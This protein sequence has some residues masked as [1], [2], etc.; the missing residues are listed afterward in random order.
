MAGWHLQQS[1]GQADEG[2]AAATAYRV[3]PP[4]TPEAADRVYS[5]GAMLTKTHAWA[6]TAILDVCLAWRWVDPVGFS[7]NAVFTYL[8]QLGHRLPGY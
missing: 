7:H 3:A 8:K 4:E 1:E 2:P 6:F 5:S